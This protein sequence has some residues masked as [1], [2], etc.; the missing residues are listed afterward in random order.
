[1]S[2]NKSQWDLISET[3]SGTRHNER[4]QQQLLY[5]AFK[6]LDD[7]D[8]FMLRQLIDNGLLLDF[9]LLKKG[10]VSA[11]GA[12]EFF[13]VNYPA[14]EITLACW[15]AYNDKVSALKLLDE[16]GA[17]ILFPTASGRDALAMA[18]WNNSIHA[19]RW[20][21]GT[22]NEK[23]WN[24]AWNQRSS[25]GKRTTRLMDAVVKRNLVAV[26]EI[27]SHVDVSAWDYSG[28]TALHYNFLQDPYE[29][30]DLQIARILIDYGAPTK[31]ED[32]DGVSVIALASTPEQE[33]LMDNVMLKEIS[34][35]AKAKADAQ[36]NKLKAKEPEPAR[37]PTE[38]GFP[39]IQKP[40][41]FKRYM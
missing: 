12:E 35:E 5:R 3:I 23:G 37:D 10:D 28:K 38:P 41:K 20:I 13:D 14:N 27:A 29:D 21:I 25:D 40:V 7:E 8:E 18:A 22:A 34:M 15:A 6:A 39:Q 2:I 33:A 4:V 19:W 9:A 17:D 16:C 11:P 36:R 26:K 30:I 31:V 24:I 1:M 32:H